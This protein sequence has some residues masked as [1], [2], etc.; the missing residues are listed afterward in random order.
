MKFT[1]LTIAPWSSYMHVFELM[2]LTWE[3]SL[4]SSGIE[5]VSSDLKTIWW[6]KCYKI[7]EPVMIWPFLIHEIRKTF[8]I[9]AYKN[10][11]FVADW[12]LC[13]LSWELAIFF[14]LIW[15]FFSNSIS[16]ETKI[17]LTP[18]K[19]KPQLMNMYLIYLDMWHHIKDMPWTFSMLE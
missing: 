11:N 7:S 12:D 19:F 16:T 18:N 5:Q 14:F 10:A 15:L 2:W 6:T 3:R 13:N 4:Y 17:W 8:F 9:W 1:P